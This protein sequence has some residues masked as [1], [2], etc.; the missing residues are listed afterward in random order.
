[1]GNYFFIC[2]NLVFPTFKAC[3]RIIFKLFEV[4]HLISLFL[5]HG[6]HLVGYV[7]QKIT[8]MIKAYFYTH[9]HLAFPTCKNLK[10][11]WSFWAETKASC[12]TRLTRHGGQDQEGHIGDVL[13]AVTFCRLTGNSGNQAVF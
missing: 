3:H 8:E 5:W 6:K 4:R 12:D 2:F 9:K 11:V 13:P 10:E 7:L 1:M